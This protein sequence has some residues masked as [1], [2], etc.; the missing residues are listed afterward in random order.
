MDSCTW[1]HQK[2]YIHQLFADTECRLI[3]SDKENDE[4]ESKE[5]E[6]SARIDD[7][8][9]DYFCKRLIRFLL[10]QLERGTQLVSLKRMPQK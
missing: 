10:S 2:T 7:K 4:R 5:A 8:D 9:N 1:T 6:L 3:K